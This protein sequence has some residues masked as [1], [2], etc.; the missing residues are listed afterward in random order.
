MEFKD[1]SKNTNEILKKSKVKAEV[2]RLETENEQVLHCLRTM[3]MTAEIVDFMH[4][5]DGYFLNTHDRYKTWW[6]V[7]KYFAGMGDLSKVKGK[8][9]CRRK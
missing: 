4:E 3:K 7:Q 2:I 9:A 8:Q 5:Y 6:E 1:Y